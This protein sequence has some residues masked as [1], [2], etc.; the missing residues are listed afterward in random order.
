MNQDLN[1]ENSTNGEGVIKKAGGE[2]W[3][4]FQTLIGGGTCI[5]HL[6]ARQ[7]TDHKEMS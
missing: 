2:G 7:A 5:R 6:R 3:R 1:D 4:K